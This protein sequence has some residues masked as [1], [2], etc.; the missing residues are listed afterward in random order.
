VTWLRDNVHSQAS[1]YSTDDLM[2][3]AT[4]RPLEVSVFREHLEKRYLA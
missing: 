4:G 1:R 3:R 2:T